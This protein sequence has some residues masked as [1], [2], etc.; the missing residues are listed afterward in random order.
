LPSEVLND[1]TRERI[2]KIIEENGYETYN[3]F[4]DIIPKNKTPE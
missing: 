4:D 2:Q 3:P 1:K